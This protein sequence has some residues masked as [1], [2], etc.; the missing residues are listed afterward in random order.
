MRSEGETLTD[1]AREALLERLAGVRRALAAAVNARDAHASPP[2]GD[3]PRAAGGPKG[4]VRLLA[5]SKRQSVAAVCALFDAG[6]QDFA[7][8]Y[9]QELATKARAVAATGRR[10]RWH[11]VGSLQ[12]NKVAAAVACAD[13]VQTVDRAALVQA[14][15]RAAHGRTTPLAVMLQ[16]NLDGPQIAG[17]ARGGCAPAALP[18]LARAVLAAP[19]LR[20]VGL[21][22]VAPRGGPGRDAF[23]QLAA[24]GRALRAMP[25]AEGACGLSMGMSDDF[26]D[27]V[28]EGATMVRIGTALF[29]PRPPPKVLSP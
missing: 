9:V 23:A 27:A 20:L 6:V 29:G 24:A 13:C 8:N 2:H 21:M 19:K 4:C 5:A 25:G 7:E 28:A 3:A 10:P 22:A 15:A 16:L 17:G 14:L 12:R 11:L 18:A 1:A 26:A